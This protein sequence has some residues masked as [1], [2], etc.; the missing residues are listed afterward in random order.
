MIY[1]DSEHKC[2]T[3]NPDGIY[4]AVESDYFTGKCEAYI[5][6]YLL[7]PD[8][9]V[10]IREDGAVFYG[11]MIAPWKDYNELDAAQREYERQ[12]LAEYEALIDEL[13]A[14]VIE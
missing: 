14:E 5:E 1:I 10:R 3:R 8:G 6:G 13:Y 2:H 12:K 11:E 9:E 7:V 4:R